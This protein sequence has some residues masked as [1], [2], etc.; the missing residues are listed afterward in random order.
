M[1][2][3]DARYAIAFDR[4]RAPGAVVAGRIFEHAAHGLRGRGLRHLKGVAARFALNQ[5]GR[6]EASIAGVGGV[7]LRDLQ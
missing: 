5:R 4:R 6:V 7:D 2:T 3:N 1:P